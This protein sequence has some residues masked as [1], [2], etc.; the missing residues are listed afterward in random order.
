MNHARH[1]PHTQ[2]RSPIATALAPLALLILAGCSTPPKE[3]ASPPAA[4]VPPPAPAKP[5]KIGLA[6]SGGGG[7]GFAHVGVIKVLEAQGV[8]V[9][10]IAGTSA[11]AFVG[12]L[13]A[14]G[15]NGF[16]LQEAAMKIE[17]APFRDWSL[18][19]R[20]LFSGKALQDYVNAQLSA[21]TTEQLPIPMGIVATDLA[22][23]QAVVFRRGDA[24]V[25]VRASCAVPGVYSPVRISGRDYVD[26]GVSSPVPVQ[27]VREMGASFVIAVDIG[28]KPRWS[29]RVESAI[30][31]LMQ[32][33]NIMGHVISREE[34]KGAD[35]V[36]SPD[37]SDVDPVSF[38]DRYK[39][40][41][42][43]EKAAT[44]GMPLLKAELQKGR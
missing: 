2:R 37:V 7:R 16:A 43:G 3:V 31:V 44:D 40:I 34:L 20:G 15:L 4:V 1:H 36:I 32:S 6:L 39:A 9:D 14:S 19:D 18:T 12:T 23:G 10:L 27:A 22:S 30:G 21:K 38:A 17:E 41:L 25:A 8:K 33:A 13:Y 5:L 42:R 29:G 35:F 26:G 28:Q 24:G 11:G